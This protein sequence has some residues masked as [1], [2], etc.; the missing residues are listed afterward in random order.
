M[1]VEYVYDKEN[2]KLKINC[3]GYIYGPSLEDHDVWM[4][5]VIDKLMELKR[6]VKVVLAE[7]RE[8]EYDMKEVKLLLEIAISIERIRREKIISLKNVVIKSCEE[9]AAERFGFLQ[10]LLNELR[11]DPIEAYKWLTREIRH[12]NVKIEREYNL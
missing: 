5:A 1:D 4:A 8:Y 12:T 7:R 6:I 10:K 2:Q 3:L 11:Y 9:H